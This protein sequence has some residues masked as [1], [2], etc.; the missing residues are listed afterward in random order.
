MKT[1]SSTLRILSFI[2]F[3]ILICNNIYSQ[4]PYV[5][6][7]SV[8]LW[9]VTASDLGGTSTFWLQDSGTTLFDGIEYRVIT[10]FF[11]DGTQL[12]RYLRE[13][14][15]TRQVFVFN[16]SINREFLYYD[17]SLEVGDSFVLDR[18][19]NPEFEVIEKDSILAPV[20]WLYQWTLQEPG[21]IIIQY[22][23]AV[24]SDDLF[25]EPYIADPVYN[26][27]CAYFDCEQIFGDNNCNHP[28]AL[29]EEKE[30]TVEICFGENYQGYSETG[31]YTYINQGLD[32]ACDTVVFLDLLANCENCDE[33]QSPCLTCEASSN[34]CL[35]CEQAD[36]R[37]GIKGCMPLFNPNENPQDD[38][39]TPLCFGGGIPNNMSWWSFVA[40]TQVVEVFIQ[41]QNCQQ[42]GGTPS[43]QGVQSGIYDA[44]FADGGKCLGGESFCTEASNGLVYNVGG[45]IP[46]NTY[47]I[48]ID[49]CNG[50]ACDYTLKIEDLEDFSIPQPDAI[51]IE[52]SFTLAGDSTLY[53]CEEE[54]L[55]VNLEHLGGGSSSQGHFFNTPGPYH[56]DMDADFHWSSNVP[57]FDSMTT[58]VFNPFKDKTIFREFW[59][60][61]D[62]EI[63]SITICLDKISNNCEEIECSDCCIEL[64][65]FED[66]SS[67]I[68]L[69]DF[70]FES[71]MYNISGGCIPELDAPNFCPDAELIFTIEDSTYSNME[72]VWT[73]SAKILEGSATPSDILWTAGLYSGSSELFVVGEP[74]MP[75]PG[76]PIQIEFREVGL[77]EI[78]LDNFE[79]IQGNSIGQSCQEI[80]I[81]DL[82]NLDFG[83]FDICELDLIQGW[84]PGNEVDN[85]PWLGGLITLSEVEASNGMI[86]SFSQDDCGCN[87]VQFIQINPL[88]SMTFYTDLD[89]D[90]F[91]DPNS[92]TQSC[93]LPPG[94][95]DNNEDC[96]DMDPA[97]N[98]GATEI[99]DNDVDEDCDGVADMS[100]GIIELDG[101]QYSIFPNPVSDNLNIH[102]DAQFFSVQ[103]FDLAGKNL[104]NILN[105]KGDKI[106]DLSGFQSGVYFI[107]IRNA[108]NELRVEKIIKM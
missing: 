21:G 26:L 99:L 16:E 97:I 22:T 107:A 44:C 31:S 59:I 88:P 104:L 39:P 108:E 10:S 55:I 8:N 49:G 80:R 70:D 77:Y 6:M 83:S 94:M 61:A 43:E 48:F 56:P 40:G 42:G 12:N 32:G 13:D 95:T 86:Q 36:L 35:F 67:I 81:A 78:C 23:E 51:S 63:D 75:S 29:Q 14:E 66:C 87:F 68:N 25:Y 103:I 53:F 11:D 58:Y 52:N 54:Y 2:A 47:H 24:G 71:V 41:T 91:G 105:C 62:S 90:G 17:F 50:T 65:R 5:P 19:P 27:N 85:I 92:A 1:A 73:W 100:T 34:D 64:T 98:P 74:N 84:E 89:M 72:G 69:E 76:L 18:W 82:T 60:D 15:N 102:T 30:E 46:G 33:N 106:I 20:G 28:E 96:D 45:L 38:Q 7:S 4:K 9:N 57:L 101:Y 93:D 37:N 3:V 79:G